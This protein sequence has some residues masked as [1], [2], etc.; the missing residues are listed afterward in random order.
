MWWT[1]IGS[2]LAEDLTLNEAL[3]RAVAHNLEIAGSRTQNA[4][5][6]WRLTDARSTFDPTLTGSVRAG[7]SRSPTNNVVDG[8]DY[9]NSASR[10]WSAG[11]SQSLPTGGSV[12]AGYSEFTSTSDSANAASGRFVSGGLDVSVSQP[13]L[14]GAGLI[15]LASIQD[16]EL[17]LRDQALAWRQQ[18]ERLALDVSDAYWGLV[19]AREGL[20]LADRSVELA[21]DQLA[22]TTERLEAGFAGSGEV[23]QVQVSVGQARQQ[24]VDAGAAL[25]A[26]RDRLARLLGAPL[27]D[28][29]GLVPVDR[30]S[31]DPVLPEREAL[32]ALATE[33]NAM[34]Q[35]A[36]IDRERSKRQLRRSRNGALPSVGLDASAGLSA[37]GTTAAEARQQILGALA[38]SWSVG[39]GVQ[40]PVLM[41]AARARLGIASLQDDAAD[42]RLAAVQQDTILAVDASVR[43]IRR[44]RGS[45]EVAGQTLDFAERSLAAQREMLAE[46]RGSTR[47]VV[48]ALESLRRA[49]VDELGAQ[50]ALQR[51]V[52]EAEQVAGTLL[53][54]LG[55]TSALEP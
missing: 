38:P 6:R 50:I 48:D 52:L 16:A 45:L 17:D 55:L 22:R 43:A 34:L 15:A 44:D 35:R 20:A 39:V 46:G 47:D 31:A 21:E 1:L 26:S 37:G 13:L 19:S 10:S 2:A 30:P 5:A 25:E 18:L 11:L 40:L 8:K 27:G 14:R 33:R 7:G 41:R 24:Q 49:E 23:L 36:L 42:V 32:L 51:S 54:T 53:E 12:S 28:A 3:E 29:D 9:V 4:I